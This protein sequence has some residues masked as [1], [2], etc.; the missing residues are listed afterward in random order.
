MELKALCNLQL[1]QN[2]IESSR[3]EELLDRAI[4]FYAYQEAYLCLKK[5]HPA[6]RL[7]KSA[8]ELEEKD[9]HIQ[10]YYQTEEINAIRSKLFI[11]A[12]TLH[13]AWLAET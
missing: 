6:A 3:G 12:M 8:K 4:T 1:E 10:S 11:A 9:T 2:E 5:I 7:P 13:E